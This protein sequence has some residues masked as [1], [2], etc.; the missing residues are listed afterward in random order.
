MLARAIG[1]Q[2]RTKEIDHEERER[3]EGRG[4]AA[5]LVRDTVCPMRTA[6]D[7]PAARAAFSCVMQCVYTLVCLAL[8]LGSTIELESS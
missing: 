8:C 6:L 5:R 2:H 3:E 1:A 4:E 7:V